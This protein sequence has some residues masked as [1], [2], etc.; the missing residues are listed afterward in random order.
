MPPKK[1]SSAAGT[2]P[3]TRAQ[4]GRKR[5]LPADDSDVEPQQPAPKKAKTKIKATKEKPAA[6]SKKAAT[7]E[8]EDEEQPKEVSA[9]ESEAEPVPKKTK[10]KAKV[11]KQQPAKRSK[12]VTPEV[13]EGEE[14]PEDEIP[15]VVVPVSKL[16]GSFDL[17]A[18][19][20]DFLSKAFLPLGTQTP[21]FDALYTEIMKVQSNKDY[22]NRI[23]LPESPHS[24]PGM[25]IGRGFNDPMEEMPFDIGLDNIE[26]VDSLPLT[27]SQKALFLSPPDEQSGITAEPTLDGHCGIDSASGFF[28]MKHCWTKLNDEG[29]KVELFQGCFS[30]DV[31]HSGMYKR[32][33]HGSSTKY[34]PNAFWAVR[35]RKD[36]NGKVIGI[37]PK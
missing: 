8:S 16:S 15:E 17:Y 2:K 27:S 7:P 23:W 21:Q 14:Q 1:S 36:T 18:M 9:D 11:T 24:E 3:A 25:F 13:S 10:A 29:E 32:K 34:P 19:K 6:K 30:I 33:G 37:G 31:W 5:Q 22:T 35:A 20:L 28:N 12:V 26:E 4:P